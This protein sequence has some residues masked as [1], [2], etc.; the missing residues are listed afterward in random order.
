MDA[1]LA[2]T[3]SDPPSQPS[4]GPRP[5]ARQRPRLA[6]LDGLRLIAALMVVSFHYIGLGDAWSAKAPHGF[7]LPVYWASEYGFLGVELF[8]LISGFVICMSAMGRPLSEFFISRVVRLYPAYWFAIIATTTVVAFW[9]EV[10]RPLNLK[11]TLT[12]FTMLQYPLQVSGVDGVYWTLWAEMRFYLLFSIVVLLG[13]TYRR[14]VAFC[15]LWTVLS[16]VTVAVNNPLMTVVFMPSQAPYF[17]AGA[18][19]FLMHRYGADAM[20]WGIVGISFLL[21][22]HQLG[23]DPKIEN[24]FS[25]VPGWFAIVLV[26]AFYAIMALIANNKVRVGWRWLTVA[27]TLTYPLY[28]L[29]QHIGWF[30]IDKLHHRVS[31]PLL[32]AGVTALMLVF[33]WLVNRLIERPVSKWMRRHLRATTDR[34]RTPRP[35]RPRLSINGGH[36]SG[37]TH[38]IEKITPIPAPH[39][40]ETAPSR[41]RDR[42]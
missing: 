12:N 37:A 25:V 14:V 7:P 32:V 38:R 23:V 36:P 20:L 6:A 15:A 26:T 21:S 29:H 16:V 3:V 13:V 24:K 5:A 27:G 19:F 2:Q 33:A 10:R 31:P 30:I 41:Q 4:S 11:D 28:L 22:I 34:Y 39:T 1:P 42:A 18:A 8:F 17:I 9:P 40:P 35:P